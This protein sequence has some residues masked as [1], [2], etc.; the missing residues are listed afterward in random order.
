LVIS[1]VINFQILRGGPL[2]KLPLNDSV[3]EFF[4]SNRRIDIYYAY[5]RR[6]KEGHSKNLVET[7]IR[8]RLMMWGHRTILLAIAALVLLTV[9]AII[10]KAKDANENEYKKELK[11]KDKQTNDISA[12][13]VENPSSEEHGSTEDPKE[14]VNVEPDPNVIA[15]MM[16][17]VTHGELHVGVEKAIVDTDNNE[18]TI[19]EPDTKDKST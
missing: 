11:M 1:W 18:G 2:R 9:L 3:I 4:R 16:D 15:P 6:L 19:C 5:A 17:V 7:N 14:Y 8:A 10:Y 13:P 12:E